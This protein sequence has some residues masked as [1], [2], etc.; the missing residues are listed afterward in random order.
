ML[1][2]GHKVHAVAVARSSGKRWFT[3]QYRELRRKSPASMK[4]GYGAMCFRRI[5]G[6]YGCGSTSSL[7]NSL[8]LVAITAATAALMANSVVCPSCICN[9]L[10][11]SGTTETDEIFMSIRRAFLPSKPGSRDEVEKGHGIYSNIGKVAAQ[12]LLSSVT[13]PGLTE[14]ADVELMNSQT[15]QE[16]PSPPTTECWRPPGLPI[17]TKTDME[18]LHRGENILQQHISKHSAMGSAVIDVNADV[19]V[20]MQT[21]QKYADYAQM[22][23][24]VRKVKIHSLQGP[25]T[26]AEFKVSRFKLRL[27]FLLTKLEGRNC[28][29][30]VLDPHSGKVGKNLLNVGYGLWFAEEPEDRP[31]GYTRVW[32]MFYF[33][34]GAIVPKFLITY[35]SFRALPRATNWIK[36]VCEA[37][38]RE[39]SKQCLLKGKKKD[40]VVLQ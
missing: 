36:P 13:V 10:S 25:T 16:T 37:K 14:M 26:C 30:F 34:Y 33:N 24:T 2:V 21:I 35:S 4:W 40:M 5:E 17:L 39:R 31:K 3:E 29:E 9:T 7:T 1:R 32:F 8:C 38:Q 15:K 12:F 11:S 23:D 20:V 28:V 27:C 19:D 6:L 22:I 18:R